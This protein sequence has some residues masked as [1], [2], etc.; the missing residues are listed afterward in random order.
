MIAIESQPLFLRNTLK[1]KKKKQKTQHAPDNL[2]LVLTYLEITEVSVQ[3]SWADLRSSKKGDTR[4]KRAETSFQMEK[5]E[6]EARMSRTQGK[7]STWDS[8][9]SCL[10]S[11]Q[12]SNYYQRG[13]W[14][15]VLSDHNTFCNLSAVRPQ[16]QGGLIWKVKLDP[17][18]SLH[19]TYNNK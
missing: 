2:L 1:W 6:R 10:L 17:F 5:H 13:G 3:T 9:P 19:F 14:L 15:Q 8:F 7:F 18:W 11:V 16:I 4:G 12:N